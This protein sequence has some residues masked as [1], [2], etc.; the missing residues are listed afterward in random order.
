[1]D[2]LIDIKDNLVRT[3][4]S[5]LENTVI[6]IAY[7]SVWDGFLSYGVH[8]HPEE[9][10]YYIDVDNVF[11]KAPKEA[12]IGGIAHEL[13]HIVTELAMPSFMGRC[14]EFLWNKFDSYTR[15]DERRTDLFVVRRGRG[16]ELLAFK[17]YLFN[18]LDWRLY[19]ISI[20]ELEG[21]VKESSKVA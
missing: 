19:G 15:Y 16:E 13:A 20:D 9:D 6:R 1:M 7:R 17:K 14:L 11:K 2:D 21:M 10:I 5:E 8:E 4:F 3:A 18:K 12:K